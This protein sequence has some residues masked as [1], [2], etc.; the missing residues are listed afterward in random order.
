MALA[1]PRFL[2]AMG[3][4]ALTF[5]VL[6]VYAR[7]AGDKEL[8]AARSAGASPLRVAAP[9]VMAAACLCVVLLAMTLEVTPWS[10][11]HLQSA[12]RA[13]KTQMPALLF[14]EGVFTM[15]TPGLTLY[16]RARE[17]AEMRGLLLHDAR[18]GK[19]VSTVL[20]RRGVVRTRPDGGAEM[21]VENGTRQEYDHATETLHRLDFARYTMALP[22]QDTGE[23]WLEAA[24]RSA[25]T[26]LWPDPQDTKAAA[27][28][29]IFILEVHRR[30]ALPLLPASLVLM[31][32]AILMGGETVRGGAGLRSVVAGAATAST[33][34]VFLVVLTAAESAG[35]P[36][37][38]PLALWTATLTPGLAALWILK[39]ED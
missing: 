15:P 7:M 9:A 29:G 33:Q 13:L 5:A 18:K 22:A 25:H 20:A 1:L 26:L 4:L 17:G 12:Q 34:A 37:W 3:P 11:A 31:A 6:F 35:G 23:R 30:L 16:A 39:R 24:E 8:I 32:L 2:E 38:G 14:R 27:Q 10:M 36:P 21:M 28:R 19:S